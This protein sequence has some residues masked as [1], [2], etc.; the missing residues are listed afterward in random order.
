M[1]DLLVGEGWPVPGPVRSWASW[2]FAL[3]A[4][5]LVTIPLWWPAGR[6][7]EDV[8]TPPWSRPTSSILA[9]PARPELFGRAE[10]P[11]VEV[12]S[13]R[14]A[15]LEPLVRGPRPLHLKIPRLRVAAPIHAMGIGPGRTM[16]VPDDV[17]TV[18]WYRFGPS[19]GAPGSAVLVGHVDSRHGAGVFF[20][21]STLRRGDEI[22]VELAEGGWKEFEVVSRSLV[23]KDHLPAGAFARR[24]DP[25]LTLITCGGAFDRAAGAYTDNVLVAAVPRS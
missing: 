7:E 22:R 4:S 5:L 18:G 8:G 15:D 1:H 23:P 6:V 3:S 19:P 9:G 21:L 16:E 13:A 25:I 11:S 14:L 10:P 17:H 12:H 24:G 2:V 20:G